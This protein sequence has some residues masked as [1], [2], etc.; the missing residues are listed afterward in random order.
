M[1][2]LDP[3]SLTDADAQDV[4]AYINAKPRSSFVFK[5]QDYRVEKLPVDAVYYHRP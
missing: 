1:P 4:A 5:D 3:G 2:Y